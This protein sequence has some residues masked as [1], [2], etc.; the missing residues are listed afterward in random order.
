MNTTL[1]LTLSIAGA[2]LG[3]LGLIAALHAVREARRWRTRCLAV[4]AGLSAV[5]SSLGAIRREFEL[6]VSISMKSGR[7]ANQ[8]EQEFSEV[9]DRLDQVEL[10]GTAP[11]FEQAI[12]SARLGVNPSKLAQRFGLSPIEAELVTRLHGRKP[13]A[14]S[15]TT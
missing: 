9:A 14:G 10:R 7:R 12:D 8:I 13:S 2:A 3:S 4:Q 1:T 6:A 11:S 15:Q 5:E